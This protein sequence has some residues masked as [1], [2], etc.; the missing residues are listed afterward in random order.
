MSEQI[1][2][3]VIFDGFT[4]DLLLPSNV[5]TEIA[6]GRPWEPE[7]CGWIDEYVRPGMTALDIGAN[8]GVHTLRLARAVG[9]QGKVVAL[10]PEPGFF[11]RLDNHLTVNGI[12]NV[13]AFCLAAYN[14]THKGVIDR[15]DGPY[16]SSAVFHPDSLHAGALAGSVSL[17]SW[18]KEPALD[19]IKCDTD[20]C[21][22][23]AFQGA[24]VILHKFRPVIVT[25]LSLDER[26]LAT[27][28]QLWGLEYTI[29][30]HS[31]TVLDAAALTQLVD[32][33]V[34]GTINVLCLPKE[35]KLA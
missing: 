1:P 9:A 14:W 5:D 21:E 4:F 19:F 35:R 2:Q 8:W 23:E 27:A 12:S 17:D 26:L 15:N 33:K 31:G 6:E 34:A 3:R 7:V 11:V 30:H 18:W 13:R 28:E 25:E 16:Y 22:L 24:G 32:E 20:G 10:E 29:R